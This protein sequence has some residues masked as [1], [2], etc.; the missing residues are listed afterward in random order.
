MSDEENQLS[1]I[2]SFICCVLDGFQGSAFVKVLMSQLT[3]IVNKL[4]S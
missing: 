1:E 4:M 2:S 3:K